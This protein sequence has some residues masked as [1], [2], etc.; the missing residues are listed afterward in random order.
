MGSH[1][2]I[3]NNLMMRKDGERNKHHYIDS[4]YLEFKP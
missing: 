4:L 2:I 1:P 3:N